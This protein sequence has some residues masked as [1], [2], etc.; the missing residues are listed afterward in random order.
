MNYSKSL[1]CLMTNYHVINPNLEF[2]FI[3]IEIHN[4]NKMRLNLNNRTTKFIER[5]KD[6]AMIEIKKS[7][8]I[9]NDIEF[10][11]CDY[12]YNLNGYARYKDLDVFSIE[13]P[14]GGKAKYG[15]GKIIEI[16]DYEFTHNIS[17]ANGSS[18]C[19]I[20]L[21]NDNI[22]LIQVIG[23]HKEGYE[24]RKLNGGT[25]IGE[26]FNKENEDNYI[27]SEIYIKT[28]D[29]NNDIRI[30]NSY[31]E[32]ERTHNGEIEDE[33]K[34]EEEIKKCEIK[35]NDE[36]I[37]FNYFY[38]FKSIGKYRII[39]SF[40]NYLSKTCYMFFSCSSLTNIDLSH[41]NTDNVTDM[42]SMF[43]G[44]SSLT[45]IN[46]S[47]CNAEKVTDMSYMFLGC[48][49]LANIDFSNFNTKNVINMIYMFSG[50]SS[51]SNIDLSH[52]NTDNVIMISYMFFK[53]YSLTYINL[54]N[55]NDV[56]MEFMFFG[57]SSLKKENIITK[58]KNILDEF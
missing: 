8:E 2:E 49:S 4:Q 52:F 17:T 47:N 32:F 5:P 22:N 3:E 21:L 11:D 31:E 16:D 1:K 7:D 57:C 15:S 41:F 44:C 43:K 6:L 30:L 29:I 50:C 56:D 28:E 55:F 35:I 53:C 13:H 58:N 26:I 33:Y 40:K 9:Y 19:P 45:N 34:N 51:L 20:I 36:L 39:Y 24:D 18:G 25:F 38:N 14:N 54:P 12:N 23:I 48:S 46:L 42:S 10:L 37:P 27:I